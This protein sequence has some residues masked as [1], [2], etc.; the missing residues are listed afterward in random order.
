MDSGNGWTILWMHN[1]VNTLI[2]ICISS[3]NGKFYV[4]LPQ[5]KKHNFLQN[6]IIKEICP[7]T[8]IQEPVI[9]GC[10]GLAHVL[11]HFVIWFQSE[12]T[13]LPQDI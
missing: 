13:L 11:L 4:I 3:E 8:R 1:T 12:Q 6:L 2:F 10:Q 7:R 5:Q 9:R